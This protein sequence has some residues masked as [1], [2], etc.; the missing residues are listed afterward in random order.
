MMAMLVDFLIVFGVLVGAGLALAVLLWA[1]E[2][3]RYW[4]D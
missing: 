2:A 3:I 4:F 1:M